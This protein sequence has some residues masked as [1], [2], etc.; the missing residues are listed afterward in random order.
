MMHGVAATL[1]YL[2][3][4]PWLEYES[5]TKEMEFGQRGARFVASRAAVKDCLLRVPLLAPQF[6]EKAWARRSMTG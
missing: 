6:L 1:N 5:A 2:I 3:L 4:I